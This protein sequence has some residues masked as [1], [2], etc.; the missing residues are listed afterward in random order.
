M[1]VSFP[2]SSTP[3]LLQ[4]A[5]MY[6]RSIKQIEDDIQASLKKVNELSGI[7]ESNTGL[8]PPALWDLTA[9][10]HTLHSAFIPHITA[11]RPGPTCV[12]T[13]QNSPCN[14]PH[15]L[16]PSEF[17]LELDRHSFI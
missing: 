1:W 12:H 15:N 9:D 16:P 11:Y 8:A 3:F 17:A 5:G 2:T 4:G 14:L 13:S 10:K 7:K 6:S